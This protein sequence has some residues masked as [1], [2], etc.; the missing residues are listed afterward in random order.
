M[1]RS[2][3]NSIGLTLLIFL[4]MGTSVGCVGRIAKTSA[5]LDESDTGPFPA[6][7]EKIVTIWLERNMRNVSSVDNV[8][9]D[10]PVP[11]YFDMPRIPITGITY[12]WT[13]EAKCWPTT[14]AGLSM[15]SVSYA[16]LLRD[17]KVVH[18]RKLVR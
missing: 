6:D 15:G 3:L 14:R 2:I 5:E 8:T 7:Y 18:S 1:R 11:G 16:F 13:T 17:G 4:V 9:V 10:R 12:G